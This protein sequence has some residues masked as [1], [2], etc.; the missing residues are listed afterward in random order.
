MKTGICNQADILYLSLF[1][2][3]SSVFV[4]VFFTLILFLSFSTDHDLVWS[5]VE[6]HW[7]FTVFAVVFQALVYIIALVCTYLCN[8][9]L[10][11]RIQKTKSG[12]EENN[13][14][15]WKG[16]FRSDRPEWS[17][18]WKWTTFKIG[19][20]YSGRTNPKWSVPFDVP[21]EISGILGEK[22]GGVGGGGRGRKKAEKK[23]TCISSAVS[24]PFF[25]LRHMCMLITIKRSWL[26]M[27]PLE[28]ANMGFD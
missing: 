4:V 25:S 20:E 18:R 10:A 28:I 19:P 14:A 5:N 11:S 7:S 26:R 23:N 1:H 2:V 15:K 6:L 21:T 13:F 9:T 27:K 24:P 12:A 8:A 22:G 3:V 16:T 17:D